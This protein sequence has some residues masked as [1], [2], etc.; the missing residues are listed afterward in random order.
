[1][2]HLPNYTK[3]D[4]TIVPSVKKTL[5]LEPQCERTILI[6]QLLSNNQ[7]SKFPQLLHW[8]WLC[9]CSKCEQD[10]T[11]RASLWKNYFN[12]S[13]NFQWWKL[14]SIQY[15][16]PPALGLKAM[17]S[18]PRNPTRQALNG[19]PTRPRTNLNF[20]DFSIFEFLK[21]SW[22]NYSIVN[23]FCIVDLNITKSP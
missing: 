5:T 1:M 22:Q 11:N 12:F 19:F 16:P 6:F 4:Y 18:P 7:N 23:C 21:F 13:I 9:N 8:T 15:P 17:K 20:N 14:V 3:H 2:C 10:P